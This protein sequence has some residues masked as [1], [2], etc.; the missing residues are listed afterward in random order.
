[1]VRKWFVATVVMNGFTFLV[2]VLTLSLQL[3]GFAIIASNKLQYFKNRQSREM[4]P[5]TLLLA[6]VS[7][8][9]NTPNIRK[10]RHKSCLILSY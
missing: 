9:L 7:V 6:H 4:G 1:M 3:L 8:S 10:K 2:H 5:E